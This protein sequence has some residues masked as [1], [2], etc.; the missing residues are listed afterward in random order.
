MRDS[1][2]AL[3]CWTAAAAAMAMLA[4]LASAHPTSVELAAKFARGE[5]M[6]AA[7]E[8]EAAASADDLAF[9]ARS[10]LAYCMTGTQEPDA[11]IIERASRDAEAALKIKPD[12]EE[13]QLQLAIALSLKSRRM[14]AMTAW[15]AGYG[16]K[17]R[18]L[19]E[20]VLKADPSNYY[21]YG[22]LAVWNVEVERRGGG[23]GAWVM[24]ASLDK[25]RSNYQAATRLAPD[26]VGIHWQYARA[27]AA[28][29][30]KAYAAEVNL[31]LNRALSATANDH[32]ERVMQ[33]RAA[34]LANVLKGDKTAARKLAEV[35]L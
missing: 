19:A 17:G 4:P 2:S 26:D 10:L 6:A 23:F 27:L 1:R 9:A 35:M 11:A 29:D 22:F 20:K 8:A 18:K 21:A 13:G 24:G 28:L 14:D 33:T 34:V 32:V 25:A 15:N 16:E 31:A 5:Y 12:H 3:A 30:A 7:S